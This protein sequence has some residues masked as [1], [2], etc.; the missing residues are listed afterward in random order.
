MP[1]SFRIFSFR[2]LAPSS[3]PLPIFPAADTSVGGQASSALPSVAPPHLPAEVSYLDRVHSGL[4]SLPDSKPRILVWRGNKVKD[5]SELHKS[6]SRSYG[7]RPLKR[8]SPSVYAQ[9]SCEKFSCSVTSGAAT[10][11][12]PFAN[13]ISTSEVHAPAV[14][15]VSFACKVETAYASRFGNDVVQQIVGLVQSSNASKPQTFQ[16]WSESLVSRFILDLQCPV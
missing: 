12:I 13:K 10:Y 14:D 4:N 3:L 8:L 16:D 2:F 7:K 11:S 1:S 9:K 5:F 15:N 6:N